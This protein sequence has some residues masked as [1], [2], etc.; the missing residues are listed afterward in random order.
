MATAMR[1]RVLFLAWAPFFSGA[2]RALLLTLRALD[3]SRYEPVVLAGTEGE[4]ASQVRAMGVPCR[5]ASLSPLDRRH[6]AAGIVSIGSVVRLALRHRAS[7]IHTNEAPCF[8]PAGYAARLLGI[9]AISHVRFPNG[10]SG[11]EWFLRPGFARALFVSQ[12]LLNEALGEAPSVFEGRSSVLHDGVE[13]Q[14]VWSAAERAHRRRELGLPVDR[15]LVGIAGQIAEVKGIWEFIA[16]AQLISARDDRTCFAVLGDDL[17]TAGTLRHAM[18][19]RVAAS[20]LT[21]RFT[22]LGFRSDAPAVV[23]AFD[24]IAVPSHVEPLGNATLEA[25]AAG[26]PVVGS[27]VGGIPEMVVDGE[28]GM[29]VPPRDPA[30]LASALEQILTSPELAERM[31][32]AARRRAQEAFG[33]AAHGA[34]LQAHYDQVVA[35]DMIAGAE[36]QVA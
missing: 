12:A 27:R 11:Y 1:R 17:K 20:G 18:E 4:F 5:V 7:I 33:L 24:L 23:Q 28:T 2:E 6:P 3:R 21:S 16:A 26:R 31:S 19:E 36:G 15:P 34:R 14:P 13:P 30:A 25:M 32:A 9:P 10:R 29:L 22:F 35:G 8:Q